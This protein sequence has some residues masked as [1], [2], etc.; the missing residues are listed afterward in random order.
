M[1]L[2]I[3]SWPQ[4]SKHVCLSI[5]F[6]K[7]GTQKGSRERALHVHQRKTKHFIAKLLAQPYGLL[8]TFSILV[9]VTFSMPWGLTINWNMS[10]IWHQRVL[11]QFIPLIPK[12]V[13][14][15]QWPLIYHL[16]KHA[17]EVGTNLMWQYWNCENWPQRISSIFYTL[18]IDWIERTRC[19]NASITL[20]HTWSISTT[21]TMAIAHKLVNSFLHLPSI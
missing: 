6:I 7:E 11:P 9:I 2:F 3:A 21:K 15:S 5:P 18:K 20:P 1:C 17:T 8:H 10:S 4:V 13:T 19:K 14:I 16:L 12:S